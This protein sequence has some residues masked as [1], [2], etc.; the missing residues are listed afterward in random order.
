MA[1]GLEFTVLAPY[2]QRLGDP[3]KWTSLILLCAPQS[4]FP[5]QVIALVSEKIN[6][7]RRLKFVFGILFLA[8]ALMMLGMHGNSFNQGVGSWWEALNALIFVWLYFWLEWGNNLVQVD[9]RKFLAELSGYYQLP[10]YDPRK[11]AISTA[12]YS[13]MAVG[14]VLAYVAG[15]SPN[16]YK[17]LPHLKTKACGV[18]CANLGTY[19]LLCI[20]LLASLC[21]IALLWLPD[22][23]PHPNPKS[24]PEHEP[25][26]L[27]RVHILKYSNEESVGNE[28]KGHSYLVQPMWILLLVTALNWVAWFPFLLYDTDWLGK[29]YSG[30]ADEYGPTHK[31]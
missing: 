5:T 24:K 25:K 6:L 17:L 8:E 11:L 21:T 23:Q 10:G 14:S 30:D 1:W 15:S 12:F 26:S 29:V 22:V 2:V 27:P 7:G 13:F 3:T 4:S 31:L 19:F 9:T 20:F 16:L 28:G 18:Y